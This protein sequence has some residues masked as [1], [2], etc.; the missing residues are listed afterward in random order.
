MWPRTVAFNPVASQR[1]LLHASLRKALAEIMQRLLF[2]ERQN[3]VHPSA[4]LPHAIAAVW[5]ARPQPAPTAG[6][7]LLVNVDVVLK[8]QT[9]VFQV[10]EAL[11][12]AG[13]PRA[14]P[15]SQ[16]TEW[17]PARQ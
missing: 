7:V 16:A 11:A 14:P 8:R 1:F 17:P 4:G 9:D 5:V 10:V 12:F 2:H 3:V 13:R 15:E 6:W